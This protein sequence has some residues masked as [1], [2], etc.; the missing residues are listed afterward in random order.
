MTSL[1]HP[2]LFSFYQMNFLNRSIIRTSEL[3]A[4]Q[5]RLSAAQAKLDQK[6]CEIFEM[7][8]IQDIYNLEEELDSIL[9]LIDAAR[10]ILHCEV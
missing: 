2:K 1:T 8:S 6:S 3:K 10:T 5:D 9:N 7:D 4:V